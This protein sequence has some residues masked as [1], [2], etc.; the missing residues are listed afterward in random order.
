MVKY[1]TTLKITFDMILYDRDAQ[2]HLMNEKFEF[3]D[4]KNHTN[5]NFITVEFNISHSPFTHP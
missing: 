3:K 5:S 2:I 1:I 4:L